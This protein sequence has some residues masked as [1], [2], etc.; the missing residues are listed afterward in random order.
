MT[1]AESLSPVEKLETPQ[2][3]ETLDFYFKF[4]ISPDGKGF[5]NDPALV[6]CRRIYPMR[7]VERV[8]GEI[9]LRDSDF[10]PIADLPVRRL[11]SFTLVD[12]QCQQ[13]AE[14]RIP[15]PVHFTL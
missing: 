13:R 14:I 9:V 12:R 3:E 10:D 1:S 2:P 6:H 11:L 4:L 8:E 7:C 5:D 15:D